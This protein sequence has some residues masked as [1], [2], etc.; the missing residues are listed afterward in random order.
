[1][2]KCWLENKIVSSTKQYS[3]SMFWKLKKSEFK[4]EWSEEIRLELFKT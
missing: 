4:T 2:I 3:F 1:M